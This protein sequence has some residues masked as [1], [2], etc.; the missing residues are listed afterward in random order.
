MDL[1]VTANRKIAVEALRENP[2]GF[3]QCQ[4]V[5]ARG[6]GGRERCAL[7]LVAYALGI[8]VSPIEGN[9]DDDNQEAYDL[10]KY[11]L[12]EESD[13]DPIWGWN[14]KGFTYEEVADKLAVL[15][16]FE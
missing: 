7:G 15:W 1:Q 3:T 8:K 13:T 4:A 9:W 11:Y 12:G 6:E 10:L 16:G 2:E 14:D 5:L